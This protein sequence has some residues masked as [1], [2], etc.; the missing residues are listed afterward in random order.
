MIVC[1]E[2]RYYGASNPNIDDY[3]TSNLQYLSSAQA[4]ADTAYFLEYFINEVRKDDKIEKVIVIGGSYTGSISAWFRM[5]YPHLVIGSIASSAPVVL[6]EDF[7]EYDEHIASVLSQRD[8]SCLTNVRDAMDAITDA[9]DSNYTAMQE[10]TGCEKIS[11]STDFLYVLADAVAGAVQYNDDNGSEDDQTVNLLCKRMN[12][13]SIGDLQARLFNFTK[14]MFRI[15][16]E[17]CLDF[18]SAFE[19]LNDTTLDNV[20]SSRQWMYQSCQE[21]GYFQI[22]SS[23]DS[24]RTRSTR[25]DLEYHEALCKNLFDIDVNITPYQIRYQQDDMM[26]TNIIWVNG[27]A[28]P[29]STLSITPL[30]NSSA[31]SN[32]VV[33]DDGR[34]ERQRWTIR[35][36]EGGSHCTDLNSPTE[37]DSASLNETREAI[38]EVFD[39]W[40]TSD[41]DDESE[42]SSSNDI[43]TA[44]IVLFIVGAVFLVIGIVLLIVSFVHCLNR[45][46]SYETIKN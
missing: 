11:N 34:T 24:T 8:E 43:S 20:S 27:G 17:S 29:W 15:Y 2:H 26:G 33:T 40:L 13:T 21:F 41:S 45:R 18:S 44:S 35:L 46:R 10:A 16:G 23:N 5:M 28:D 42:S 32:V 19:K 4:L 30:S 12:D 25:I 1:L 9:I 38:V 22:A 37:S 31:R 6:K 14:E 36:I 7:N 3:S 39:K